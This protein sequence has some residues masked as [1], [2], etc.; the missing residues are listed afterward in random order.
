MVQL[1]LQKDFMCLFTVNTKLNV[2]KIQDIIELLNLEKLSKIKCLPSSKT[3]LLPCDC[4][5]L[6]C[7][8]VEMVD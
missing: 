2:F 8:A 4:N 5:L 3:A 7:S 6:G 1:Y